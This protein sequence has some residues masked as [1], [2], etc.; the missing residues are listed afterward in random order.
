MDP[1]VAAAIRL[2]HRVAAG[3]VH[4]AREVVAHAVA[5]KEAHAE[6]F[7]NALSEARAAVANKDLKDPEFNSQARQAML[8]ALAAT[9]LIADINDPKW[10]K[11]SAEEVAKMLADADIDPSKI[12]DPAVAA[13]IR[14]AK[15]VAAG[16]VHAARELVAQHIAAE[17]HEAHKH[18][19]AVAT[20]HA[21]V[22]NKT[23]KDPHFNAHVKSTMM[24][25]LLAAGVISDINDPKWHSMSAEEAAKML[26]DA[27]IDPSKITDPAL[28]AAIRLAHRVAA[29]D[30]HAARHVA[31][32]AVAAK[33]AHHEHHQRA[34][35]EAH[36][37]VADKHL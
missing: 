26:A 4:A 3:D 6:H 16:D 10:Q 25:A 27:D 24:K 17:V 1:A 5:L 20:A 28:A 36:A 37:A 15:R 21:L 23:L 11:M 32:H 33:Q 7:E 34:L 12:K 31:A 19:H 14:L 35:A 13:A 8:K 9:G 18:A 30:V 2:A 29:G 22:A